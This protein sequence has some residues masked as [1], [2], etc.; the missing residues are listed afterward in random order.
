M[1]LRI[2]IITIIVLVGAAFLA[3]SN[4]YTDKVT[5]PILKG[6]KEIRSYFSDELGISAPVEE[7]MV[8]K[9]KDQNGKWQF[10]N[11]KPSEGVA[12]EIK[13]YKSDDNVVPATK[14]PEKD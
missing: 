4:S 14:I 5:H 6:L 12:T 2:L 10:S 7:T 9:W 13:V 3:P 8:Y 1:F 11:T